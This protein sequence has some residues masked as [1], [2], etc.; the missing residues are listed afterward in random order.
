MDKDIAFLLSFVPSN[1]I[2]GIV[3]KELFP[4]FYITGSY[5]GDLELSNKVK[6]IRDKYC[7]G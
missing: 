4:A 2:Y 5:G 3:E 1:L 7:A 6:R